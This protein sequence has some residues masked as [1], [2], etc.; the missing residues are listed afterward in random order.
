MS[1]VALTIAA[2]TS[3]LATAGMISEHWWED[4][5]GEDFF[6]TGQEVYFFAMCVGWVLYVIFSLSEHRRFNIDKLLAELDGFDPRSGIVLLAATNRP[7]VLDPALKRAG[8]FD[9]EIVVDGQRRMI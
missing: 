1:R 6:L 2:C 8:R 4:W 9:R 5:Y 3:L 7:E